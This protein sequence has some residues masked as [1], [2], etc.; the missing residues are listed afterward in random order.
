[1]YA[2]AMP[3]ETPAERESSTLEWTPD[4]VE[5]RFLGRV[6]YARAWEL[7]DQLATSV[8]EGKLPPTLLLLEHPHT[9]TFGRRGKE[10]NLLWAAEE[11]EQRGVEVH[12]VDR[13][14]DVTYHG[15]G[16]LVGYPLIPLGEVD[17][18]GHLPGPDYVGYLRRLEETLILS[19]EA[20][21]VAASRLEG[22][23]GV[24]ITP[25]EARR[26]PLA[27]AALGQEPSKIA[28]IGVKVDAQGV[29]RHGFALNI[30]P[31]M[32]YWQGIVPCGIDD[33]AIV[34][35]ADLLPDPPSLR[36]VADEVATAFAH[37][38]ELDL[39]WREPLLQTD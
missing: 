6:S 4:K 14:G 12:W 22:L 3:R 24:W 25:Q 35:L 17:A 29:S 39:Y 23:T 27:P 9:Y 20:F 28:S 19:L 5:A 37:V 31:D 11:L 15:P 36:Q 1:M 16:Q 13:G 2:R 30:D 8:A 34:S 18:R 10:Q 32:N 7:Q 21:D 38:F 33:K 26:F